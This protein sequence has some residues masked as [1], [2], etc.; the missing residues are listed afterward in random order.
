MSMPPS[1]GVSATDILPSLPVDSSAIPATGGRLSLE[2][3]DRFIAAAGAELRGLIEHAGHNPEAL[4]TSTLLQVQKDIVPYAVAESLAALGHSG[5]SY[6]QARVKWT[7]AIERWKR[8]SQTVASAPNSAMSNVDED[9]PSS[10]W[11][12]RGF[13]F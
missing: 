7:Q 11:T 9:G 5:P 4:P 12:S 8:A 6:T 13:K 2:S 10:P 3:I 1:F